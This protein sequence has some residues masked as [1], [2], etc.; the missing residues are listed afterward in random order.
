MIT[1]ETEICN[2]ISQSFYDNTVFSLDLNLITCT[3][4]HTG[5][6]VWYGSYTRMLRLEDQIIPLKIARVFCNS[7]HHTHALLLSSIVPYSQI[8][9]ELHASIAEAYENGSGYKP[10]LDT[11]SCIDENTISS[12]VRS[13]RLHWRER[14][15]SHSVPLYP[16]SSLV[17]SCFAFF[18]RP[19]M[20]IKRTCNKLFSP[21]T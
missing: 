19:F 9:L 14:L 2:P 21:P 17:R 6:L 15:R 7:C 8:P 18:A 16:L 10:I 13:F 4:G 3:C 20:Q 1:I 5:C 11:Q 12:I